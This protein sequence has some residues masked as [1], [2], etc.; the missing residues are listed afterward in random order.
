[1]KYIITILCV[2]SIISC[3]KEELKGIDDIDMYSNPYD[4]SS[5]IELINVKFVKTKKCDSA[6]A[7]IT[8]TYTMRGLNEPRVDAILFGDHI[9]PYSTRASSLPLVVDCK[10]PI[11]Y[12][13]RLR[14]A[15]FGPIPPKYIENG[16]RTYTP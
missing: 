3:K 6:V 9:I 14:V 16:F 4:P 13:V 15:G 11:T 8:P 7:K 10:K 12:Q 1:M 5:G 2:L